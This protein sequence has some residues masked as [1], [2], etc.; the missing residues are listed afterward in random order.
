MQAPFRKTVNRIDRLLE[1]KETVTGMKNEKGK[2][3]KSEKIRLFDAIRADDLAGVKAI[4]AEDPSA[5]NA[6][7]PKKPLDTRGMSPLQVSLC[8]G[9]HKKIAWLLLESGA[10]VNYLPDRIWAEEARPVLFDGVNAAIWNARRYAWDGKNT[11]PLH[12]EWKHTKEEADDAF[13]FL[14]RMLELGADV[15]LTDHYGRNCLMEAVAEANNLCPVKNQNTGEYYTGR[16]ITPEMREDLR[17]I[18]KLLIDAGADRE[19]VSAYSKKSI[20]EQYENEPVW[21]I[22]GDLFAAV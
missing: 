20:R 22:C 3:Q 19:N 16:P 8:T 21:Q 12:L 14:R 18:F 11:V 7:A 6:V 13:C 1:R 2:Q 15:S 5:V 9:R 17:R 10:D 4:L